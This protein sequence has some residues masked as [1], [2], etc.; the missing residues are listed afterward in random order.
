MFSELWNAIKEILCPAPAKPY[1]PPYPIF[2]TYAHRDANRKA[3]LTMLAWSEGTLNIPNSDNGYRAL[4]GG[5]TFDSYAFHPHKLVWIRRINQ[6]SDAAGRYQIMY[7]DWTPYIEKLGLKDFSPQYQDAWAL[8][9]FREI[10]ALDDIDAG[11]FSQAVAKAGNRWASLPGSKFGQTIRSF[12]EVKDA[13][14]KAGGQ[15]AA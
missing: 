5:T 9:A 1:M 8:N 12:A 13:Y 7:R 3:F 6:Y 14:S 15:F 11:R 2:N 10:N 4:I